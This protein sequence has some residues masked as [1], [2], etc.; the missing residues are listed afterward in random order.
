VTVTV[1]QTAAPTITLQYS[2]A[3]AY[4]GLCYPAR[5]AA[6]EVALRA[7]TCLSVILGAGPSTGHPP[8]VQPGSGDLRYLGPRRPP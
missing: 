1:P 4:P 2:S 7:D 3:W 8:R 5:P 6:R